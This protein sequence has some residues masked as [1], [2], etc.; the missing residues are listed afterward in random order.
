MNMLKL[1]TVSTVP[2]HFNKQEKYN[3]NKVVRFTTYT[4]CDFNLAL[5]RDP[6]VP[7]TIIAR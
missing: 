5:S 7:F 6:P 1:G 2:L 4:L 3:I